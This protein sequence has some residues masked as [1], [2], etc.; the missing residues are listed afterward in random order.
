MA[1]T[2]G[3]TLAPEKVFTGTVLSLSPA[4]HVFD[5]ANTRPRDEKNM[6]IRLDQE[7]HSKKKTRWLL[8]SRPVTLSVMIRKPY[9]Q[10]AVLNLVL[11]M[12]RHVPLWN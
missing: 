6:A 7:V 8:G 10:K 3:S 4:V 9:L 12:I 5:D 1:N 2:A 11:F